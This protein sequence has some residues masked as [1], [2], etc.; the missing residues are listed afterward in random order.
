MHP[1]EGNK[2]GEGAGTHVLQR[3]AKG[4]GIVWIGEKGAEG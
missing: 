3:A 4:S 1:E 2:A